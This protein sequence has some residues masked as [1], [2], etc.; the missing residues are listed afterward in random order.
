MPAQTT[1][2]DL[3]QRHLME[4]N[5]LP[6]CAFICI[7]HSVD[8]LSGVT[9]SVHVHVYVY[10]FKVDYMCVTDATTEAENSGASVS[11]A[12]SALLSYK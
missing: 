3:Q 2:I 10:R 4:L 12:G 9:C 6:T 5:C 8:P 1:N 11:S 7:I